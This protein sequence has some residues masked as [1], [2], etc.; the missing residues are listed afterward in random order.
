MPNSSG[1]GEYHECGVV[2]PCL[3]NGERVN[4]TTE[5]YLNCE[6]PI[7]G[8]RESRCPPTRFTQITNFVMCCCL[9]EQFGA[10]PRSMQSR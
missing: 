4:Y 6:G 9:I 7:A 10:F 2:I 3:L 8:G 1:F 5:M